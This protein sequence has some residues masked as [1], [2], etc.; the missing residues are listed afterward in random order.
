MECQ[1]GM[2]IGFYP[3]NTDCD[4]DADTEMNMNICAGGL[5]AASTK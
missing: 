2:G 5:P 1:I 4:T 3:N